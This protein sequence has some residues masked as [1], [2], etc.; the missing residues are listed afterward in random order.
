MVLLTSCEDADFSL[1]GNR[2]VST[3]MFNITS[4]NNNGKIKTVFLESGFFKYDNTR[5]TNVFPYKK[6][7]T[8]EINFA[9]NV[10]FEYEDKATDNFSVYTITMEIL[11]DNI[12]VDKR[13]YFIDKPGTKVGFNAVVNK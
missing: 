4:N 6:S 3:I 9:A 1:D 8:D 11:R 10:A 13:E 7:Y 2:A 12:L 5:T